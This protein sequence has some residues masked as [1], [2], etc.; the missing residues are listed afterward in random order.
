MYKY[1]FLG[2]IPVMNFVIPYPFL[3]LNHFT[4]PKTFVAM[5]F[6]SPS[7]GAAVVRPQVAAPCAEA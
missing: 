1:I 4:V 3:A 2:V 6:L 5:T 7:A